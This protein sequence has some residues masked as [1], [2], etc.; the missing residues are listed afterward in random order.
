MGSGVQ[1]PHHQGKAPHVD[2]DDGGGSEVEEDGENGDGEKEE[3]GDDVE[4]ENFC[5]CFRPCH[6]FVLSTAYFKLQAVT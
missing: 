6:I 4:K 1:R 5:L 3:D 2:G